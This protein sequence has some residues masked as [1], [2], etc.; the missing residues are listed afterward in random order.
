MNAVI[1]YCLSCKR[2]YFFREENSK[3]DQCPQCD[4]KLE[5]KAEGWEEFK[6][7][8]CDYRLDVSTLKMHGNLNRI[9]EGELKCKYDNE[10]MN[11]VGI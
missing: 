10:T 9:P 2:G 7:T 5:T 8:Q 1:Y 4:Q 11:I 6:C 3:P